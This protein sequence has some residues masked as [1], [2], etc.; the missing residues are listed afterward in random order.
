MLI[1]LVREKL[2]VDDQKVSESNKIAGSFN[3]FLTNIGTKLSSEIKSS[4]LSFK[5]FL[6]HLSPLNFEFKTIEEGTTLKFIDSLQPK[7][8]CD[9]DGLSTKM[10]EIIKNE[11]SQPITLIINQS[12][13]SATFLDKLKLAKWCLYIKGR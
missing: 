5:H 11:I 13:L 8:M 7:D 10:L 6:K 4:N 1:W 2:V 3:N 12:I 9:S